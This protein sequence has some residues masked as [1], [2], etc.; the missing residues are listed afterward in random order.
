MTLSYTP[1][2]VVSPKEKDKEKK[3]NINND[4]AILPSYDTIHVQGTHP[5]F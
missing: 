2:Y 1:S 3:R 5:F 4:L